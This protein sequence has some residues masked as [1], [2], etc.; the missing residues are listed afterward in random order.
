MVAVAA[1]RSGP[2]LLTPEQCS[3][4][5]GAPGYLIFDGPGGLSGAEI[6]SKVEVARMIPDNLFDE[7]T[8]ADVTLD[9]FESTGT[10]IFWRVAT[11]NGVAD[12]VFERLQDGS[13]EPAHVFSCDGATL[14]VVKDV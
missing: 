3:K 2:D 11:V 14:Q 1:G 8:E 13:Y 12:F 7:V 6:D 9:A 5:G 4:A 10:A